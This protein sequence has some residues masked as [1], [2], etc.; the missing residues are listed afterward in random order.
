MN[1]SK[2]IIWF[3]TRHMPC[4]AQADELEHLFPDHELITCNKM[5]TNVE[6]LIDFYEDNHG[7]EMVVILPLTMI[8]RLVDRGYQPVR[9]IMRT[10]GENDLYD[11]FEV[12]QRGNT[13]YLKFIAFERVTGINVSTER[14]FLDVRRPS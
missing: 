7:D 11:I 6:H 3:S 1:K 4:T 5:F 8:R 13:S 12:K 10:V 14:L 9:S 2:R